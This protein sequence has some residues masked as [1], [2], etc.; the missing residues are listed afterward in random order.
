MHLRSLLALSITLLFACSDAP[1]ETPSV[2]IQEHSLSASG[3]HGLSPW[4]AVE[5]SETAMLSLVATSA[6]TGEST[7][8]RS[9]A[10]AI[11]HAAMLP[12]TADDTFSI[13]I[14][15]DNGEETVVEWSTDPL[16]ADFPPIEV[17]VA[18]PGAGGF[19]L[20]DLYRWIPETDTG[21]GMI[22]IVDDQ[23]RPV[24]WFRAD[25]NIQD[26]GVSR[27]GSIIYGDGE[28]GGFEIDWDG[29]VLEEWTSE[30]VDGAPIHHEFHETVDDTLLFLTTEVMTLDDYPDPQGGEEPITVHMVGDVAV[31]MTRD[32]EVLHSHSTFDFLDPYEDVGFDS[33]FSY[34][35]WFYAEQYGATADWT[36]CNSIIHDPHDD[37]LILSSRHLEG[38]I[39]ID[40][41]T[42]ERI[43]FLSSMGDL[44]MVGDGTWLSHQH[45]PF[46]IGPN[47][48]LIYDN[49][50]RPENGEPGSRAVVLEVD[51]EAMTVSQIWEYRGTE[52]YVAP[53]VGD[54]DLTPSGTVLITDGGLVGDFELSPLD[55]ANHKMARI[56][57]V[58]FDEDKELVF[59]IRVSD[60]SEGERIGY[61]IYRSDRLQQLG[62]PR[63][64][65][66]D[67]QQRN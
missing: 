37:T 16:P 14:R 62:P 38:L 67:R 1:S 10:A 63:G 19:T 52:T 31:E 27:R 6:T 60:S 35:D 36:H 13:A 45:S 28:D 57:E 17:V 24:W 15:P 25:H 50:N 55:P 61:M 21:W 58:T 26:V 53:F 29:Q 54:A 3:E 5:L 56:R 66:A 20:F 12:L 59:E 47:R 11:T 9:S 43:W 32:G 46:V 30:S 40:R 8:W 48:Y 2:S 64:S 42:G 4:F 34:W 65:D 49:G 33:F 23:G 44:S 51:P 7:E 18:N 39:K 41:Q 22:I